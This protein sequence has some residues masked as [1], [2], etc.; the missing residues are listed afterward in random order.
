[1][2]NVEWGCA[3]RPVSR[4]Q[5]STFNIQH[6][7]F[8]FLLLLL[9]AGCSAR[10]NDNRE[11]LEFWA[12][13][14]EG[15]IVQNLIPEFE[16]RNPGIHVVVQQ[17]PWSAAHEKLLTAFVGEATP[18][19]AHMGNTWVP[20]FVAIHALDDLGPF[21]ASST[22]VK[23][24][25]YFP[26]IWA[27]N[28]VGTTLYGIPWYVDTRVVFYRSDVLA[29]VGFPHGTRTWAEWRE[30]MARIHQR[31]LCKWAI[32]I[33]TNEWDPLT[34]LALSAHSTLL[35]PDGTRGA[36]SQPQ[37]A[38]A[39]NFYVSFFRDGFAPS[40]SNS[41]IANLYQ[42]FGQGDFAMYI[43]GPWNVGEF[44]RRLPPE[45][46]DKWA[47]MPLPA[48]DASEPTGISMAGGGSLVVFRASKH[49]AAAR[50]LIEFL[51]EP[52]QQVRFYQLTGDLPARRT[53]WLSP[54]LANDSRFPA[55]R[56]QLEHVEP[57]PRVPEWEQ[58][59]TAIFDRGEAAARG[60]VTPAVA[61]RQLDTRA[62][63]LLEK[64]R[65]MISRSRGLAVAGSRG[66]SSEQ[67]EVAD[68]ALTSRAFSPAFFSGG[69]GADRR[70]RG[71]LARTRSV[72]RDSRVNAPLIRLRHPSTRFARSE[73]AL[74]P[75]QETAGGE[76]LLT[77][78]TG[79]RLKRPREKCGPA[80]APRDRET[81]QLRDPK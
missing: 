34:M 25:D 53:A 70:M 71:R 64:R 42:Q 1:M 74:L 73:Q 69:E 28:V 65:W 58:I 13:G 46:Q 63:E 66:E 56:I 32:L 60:Q 2:L 55:F 11:R 47:T 17:I 75:P 76:G 72:D 77:K 38:D 80:P 48:H 16:R 20:E 51:A 62:D 7:T 45:M 41:Q 37:F 27:T 8:A 19:M 9:L 33:P 31:G 15:E 30:A 22:V 61:L 36:F 67:I 6:S 35:T 10:T 43:T 14:S 39:F 12:L 68:A 4:I 21:A 79:E 52:A 29:A 44:R 18:D 81:A 23:Q 54:L 59:A 5:H 3:Q 24:G 50:K 40:V 78:G 26:G 57:L 49:K